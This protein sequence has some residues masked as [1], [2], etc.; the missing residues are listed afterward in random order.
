MMADISAFSPPRAANDRE[1]G[2]APEA[3]QRAPRWR[4]VQPS[5][6][7]GFAPAFGFTLFYLSFFLLLPLAAL[8]L[9]PWEAG[10]DHFWRAIADAR[11]LDALKLSFGA[12]FIA[13]AINLVFGTIV[14]WVLVRYDFP[15]KGLF[16][17]FVDLPFAL[18]TA[19]A[20][21][22]LA[23]IYA[24]NGAL[25]SL[26]GILGLRIAYTPLGVMIALIFVGFP[27][28]VRSI[29]PVLAD[30]GLDEEEA[31]ATLGASRLTT[32]IQI[33]LPAILP[34]MITGFALAFARAVGEYGSVIFIAGNIPNLSEIAPLLIVIRLD[35]FDYAGAAAIGLVML[36]LSF[37][38]LF[39]LNVLEAAAARRGRL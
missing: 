33:V 1:N 19:V 2:G 34:A 11:T 16:D 14:A 4:F 32:V 31:A 30:L 9:R 7:G 29:Q 27:F 22:S 24:P 5:V 6:L 38:I 28:F 37:A 20:G 21:I 18:P 26:A 35:E 3:G 13:A 39:L 36:V 17:A 25:G 12:A 8:A 10:F 15:G 23:A